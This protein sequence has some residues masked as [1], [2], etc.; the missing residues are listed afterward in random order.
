MLQAF[1]SLKTTGMI[2]VTIQKELLLN[3]FLPY[4]KI[5]FAR[6]PKKNADNLAQLYYS[7]QLKKT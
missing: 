3:F 5:I 4:E 2:N 7:H 1:F 6:N